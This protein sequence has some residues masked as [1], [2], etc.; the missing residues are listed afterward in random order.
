[1][2]NAIKKTILLA[3]SIGFIAT[4]IIL[5]IF[6]ENMDVFAA[7]TFTIPNAA[8]LVFGLCILIPLFLINRKHGEAIE[9]FL[10]K[11]TLIMLLISLALLLGFRLLVSTEGYFTPG[12]D[13][14][15]VLN[16]TISLIRGT[17]ITNP[18]YYSR[19]PNNLLIIWLY[20]F[21]GKAAVLIGIDAI[22]CVLLAFQSVICI[23]SILLVFIITRDMSGSIKT[24][25]FAY[26]LAYLFVGLSPWF[27]I[28]YSDATG[29]IFPLL[30]IRIWQISKKCQRQIVK[31]LLRVLLGILSM[32]SFYI[33]PQLFIAF[34]AVIIIDLVGLLKKETPVQS[35]SLQREIVSV[36]ADLAS[37]LAGIALFL[38][39]YNY[40][41][42]PSI[43]IKIDPE[44][45]AGVNHYIMMGLNDSTDGVYSDPDYVYSYSFVTNAERDAADMDLAL[46]R[47]K[48][49]GAIGL[50]RHL[51]DKQVVNYGDGTF[52]W[53]IEGGFFDTWSSRTVSGIGRFIKYTINGSGIKYQI[54]KNTSQMIWLTIMLM[55]VF[56]P[57]SNVFKKTKTPSDTFDMDMLLVLVLS[58]IGLTVFELLFEARA[59]Y[60]FCYAPVYV[61]MA[62]IGF[63]NLCHVLRRK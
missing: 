7:N 6:R 37:V 25:W 39:I 32:T 34:I 57:F 28:A 63:R 61:I 31:L 10:S 53:L 52:G 43:P 12:W 20:S 42:V 62:S 18:E 40:L 23:I 46:Q 51:A 49:Y 41:I 15:T 60:L 36:T 50:L 55:I 2:Y 30:I 19:F 11:N 47:I 13:A 54:F 56:M 4:L 5:V 35:I 44:M 24:A 26:S 59:R 45:R 27:M 22:G 1:M 14:G 29:I 58:V 48:D 21:I 33:K 16:T 17:D 9:R 8:L 38:A 3:S